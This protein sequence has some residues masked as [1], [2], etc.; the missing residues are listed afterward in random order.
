MK[1]S[2]ALSLTLAFMFN[3]VTTNAAVKDAKTEQ[4]IASLKADA[5][6]YNQAPSYENLIK[7]IVPSKSAALLEYLQKE[8]KAGHLNDNFPK[9]EVLPTGQIK[10]DTAM[11]ELV[12]YEKGIFIINNYEVKLNFRDSLADRMSYIERALRRNQATFWQWVIPQADA[13]GFDIKATV[14]SLTERFTVDSKSKAVVEALDEYQKGGDKYGIERFAC[15]NGQTSFVLK[16]ARG[17]TDFKIENVSSDEVQA[18]VEKD[19]K[20]EAHVQ[21]ERDERR[22]SGRTDTGD[23]IAAAAAAARRQADRNYI[24]NNMRRV[25][26][27]MPFKGGRVEKV[28]YLDIST[29]PPRVKVVQTKS[30]KPSLVDSKGNDICYSFYFGSK[31][32]GCEA[33]AIPDSPLALQSFTTIDSRQGLDFSASYSEF[34]KVKDQFARVYAATPKSVGLV[35]AAGGCCDE[36]ASNPQSKSKD[37]DRYIGEN[38]S[39]AKR[40]IAPNSPTAR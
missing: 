19:A 2:C 16:S 18:L 8:K 6:K 27:T 21:L 31:K 15:Q 12:D 40:G 24:S 23:Q 36:K 34:A 9:I 26:A 11:I 35:Q 28:F 38:Y 39:A 3:V 4:L 10:V 22:I 5:E 1:L 29:R 37:C 32:T 17:E 7:H 25:T 14:G 33:Y 13:A 30:G 20:P